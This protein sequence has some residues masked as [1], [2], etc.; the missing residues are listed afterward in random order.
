MVQISNDKAMKLI[1]SAN[2]LVAQ[3]SLLS[4]EILACISDQ[5]KGNELVP[6]LRKTNDPKILKKFLTTAKKLKKMRKVK[7]GKRAKKV[8]A[9]EAPKAEEA[10]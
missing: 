8:K 4:T 7:R 1:A 5:P 6:T 2:A 10:K 3:A 9:E